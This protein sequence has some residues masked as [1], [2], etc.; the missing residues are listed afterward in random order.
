MPATDEL[1]TTIPSRR[2]LRAERGQTSVLEP[3][4]WSAPCDIPASI[5][6]TSEDGYPEV[7]GER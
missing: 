5:W 2:G 6:I 7:E 4:T 1:T 3:K